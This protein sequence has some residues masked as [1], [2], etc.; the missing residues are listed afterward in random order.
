MI[1][2]EKAL[3]SISKREKAD[4][5]LSICRVELKPEDD[6]RIK[7]MKILYPKEIDNDDDER[8]GGD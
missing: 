3:L 6:Y 1:E 4:G 2:K 5:I 7:G 8:I